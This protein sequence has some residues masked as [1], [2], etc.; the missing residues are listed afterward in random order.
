VLARAVRNTGLAEVVAV[1]ARQSAKAD[2]LAREFPGARGVELDDLLNLGLDAVVVALPHHV[3][4]A[5][6]PR[7]LD[8]GL[9]LA[10][11]LA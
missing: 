5:F 7:A 10:V 3:Q 6:V 11:L 4:D 9:P 8:A 2:V 1:G